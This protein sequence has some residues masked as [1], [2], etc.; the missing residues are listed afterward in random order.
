MKTTV[1]SFSELPT[2]ELYAVLQLRSEVFVVEQDCVYQDLDGKDQKALHILGYEQDQLVAYTR[3][4]KPGDYFE[5]S[6]IGRVVVSPQH[7]GKSYGQEIM[8]ASL[9]FAKAE[10]Y[11]SIKISAQCYLD[12]F[13]TDLGFVFTGEKYLEDGIPHQAMLLEF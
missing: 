1:K 3:I 13:Y 9:A 12:K 4:F 10:N 8:K 11:T 2:Q 5:Q 7:R 6:S